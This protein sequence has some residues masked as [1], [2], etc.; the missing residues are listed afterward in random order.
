MST[1]NIL[2]VGLNAVTNESE[3]SVT[4][5]NYESLAEQVQVVNPNKFSERNLLDKN[6]GLPSLT[7][8]MQKNMG[9][10]SKLHKSKE[11]KNELVYDEL[12][13]LYR[14][15]AHD[16]APKYKL[17]DSIRLANRIGRS[18]EIKH[19]RRQQIDLDR[20]TRLAEQEAQL[21]KKEQ[22]ITYAAR[23]TLEERLAEDEAML[24]KESIPTTQQDF[25]EDE[26]AQFEISNNNF[27]RQ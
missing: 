21:N 10:I 26:I 5:V 24:E 13:K 12:V 2:D 1:N 9:K 25:V 23:K 27:D 19:Y 4:V 7:R 8:R 14:L 22:V 6:T 17:K 18:S 15:W 11:N 16:V 20:S 3:E